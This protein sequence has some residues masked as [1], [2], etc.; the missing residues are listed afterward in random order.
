MEDTQQVKEYERHTRCGIPYKQVKGYERH[1]RCGS[2]SIQRKQQIVR[3][4]SEK[5]G[6]Q[7]QNI[8]EQEET[9]TETD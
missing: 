8:L 7:L 6:R 1:T 5:L 2:P 3:A 9:D 4:T